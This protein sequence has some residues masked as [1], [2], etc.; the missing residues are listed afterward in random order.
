M[1]DIN[2]IKIPEGEYCYDQREG[3]I[4]KIDFCE[5]MGGEFAAP[6]GS[7]YAKYTYWLV[8]TY[9]RLMDEFSKLLAVE[10]CNVCSNR[11][12]NTGGE[13]EEKT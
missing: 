1:R 10:K 4:N 3:S 12:N 13:D 6:D 11:K 7:W 9:E 8:E 5:G 2:N